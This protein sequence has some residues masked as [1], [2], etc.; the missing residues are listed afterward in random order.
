MELVFS[1]WELVFATASPF[2]TA[3]LMSEL[4]KWYRKNHEESDLHSN[5]TG[6]AGAVLRAQSLFG[7]DQGPICVPLANARRLFQTAQLASCRAS[8][9]S[10]SRALFET[11]VK[12]S[13]RA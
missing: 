5:L 10:N 4:I 6:S 12:P 11:R 9:R 1:S 7:A 13:L 3:R 2:D 8:T